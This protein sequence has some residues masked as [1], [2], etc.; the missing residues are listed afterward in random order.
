MDKTRC[1]DIFY[2]VRNTGI[3]VFVIDIGKEFDN[4]SLQ[5]VL[6][7]PQIVLSPFDRLVGSFIS[8]AGVAIEDETS[9]KNRFQHINHCMMYDAVPE[10]CGTDQ[11]RFG[12]GNP[13]AVIRTRYPL[14]IA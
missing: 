8:A 10:W 14:I 5:K 6:V 11:T 9:F 12:I 2:H 1:F 3:H 4:V 13:K 7:T